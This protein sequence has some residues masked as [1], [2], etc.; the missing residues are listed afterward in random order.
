[1]SAKI[2]VKELPDAPS[3]KRPKPNTKKVEDIGHRNKRLAMVAKA[4]QDREKI[5]KLYRKGVPRS[6]IARIVGVEKGTVIGAISRGFM[7]GDLREYVVSDDEKQ[8]IELY[9]SGMT[10]KM[11]SQE[12]GVTEGTVSGMVHRLRQE[13][14]LGYRK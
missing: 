4:Q 11:M 2:K 1:M 8:L 6:D 7:Y 13:G 10:Y 5:Y 12:L 9:K 14:Y 3:P